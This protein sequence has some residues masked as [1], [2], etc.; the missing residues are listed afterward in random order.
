VHRRPRLIHNL[1]SGGERR[2]PRTAKLCFIIAA[3]FDATSVAGETI[4][5]KYYGRLDLAPF[6]CAEVTRSNFVNRVCYDQAQQFMVARLRS[7]YH[8][9]CEIPT[10]TYNA[11]L[12][13]PSMGQYYNANIKGAGADGP[14]DCR[15]HRAPKY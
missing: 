2:P 15:T 1:A 11:F 14:F 5:V 6:V 8:S 9:Y 7:V 13:A 12:A 3:L 10:S 4:D